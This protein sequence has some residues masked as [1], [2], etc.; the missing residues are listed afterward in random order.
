[1]EMRRELNSVSIWDGGMPTSILSL[2]SA[3]EVSACRVQ[4][5]YAKISYINVHVF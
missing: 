2:V 1:M 5:R 4:D 3:V